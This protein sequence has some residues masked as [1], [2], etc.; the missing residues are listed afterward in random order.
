MKMRP[1]K[2]LLSRHAA[3]EIIRSNIKPLDKVEKVSLEEAAGRVLA[4][5]AVARFNVPPF[6]R[7]SMDGYA[8][9]A[10]DTYGAS[11]FSPNKLIVLGEQHAGEKFQAQVGQ[12]ECVQVATGSPIPQGSDAVVMVEHTKLDDTH[13]EIHQPAYPGANISPE[14]EDIRKGD[15][16]VKTGE[17]LTSSKVGALAAL[18][19]ESVKVYA[20]PK[21]AVISTG[22]EVIPL[23]VKL[24]AG[25][26]YDVNSFTLS[27][28]IS[29]N[30]CTPLRLGIV[31]DDRRSLED[32]LFEAVNHD[33]VVFSGG[34]SVG[35]RDLLYDVVEEKGEVLFH[36]LQVKPGKPTLFGLVEGTP[37][38][39]MPG[40]PTSCL[41]N[42]QLFLAPALRIA[43]RLP[44]HVPRQ[45]KARM[46]VRVVSSSGR[47]QFLTV[48][49][50]GDQAYPVFKKSGAIT[51]MT[52]ADGY[53]V[54]PINADVIEEG[55]EIT[56]TLFG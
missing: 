51:S 36:G 6:N 56:V 22:S 11:I 29:E 25:Q 13:V 47:E 40:Y 15:V 20:K 34:S 7:A 1:F 26:I 4:K 38:F 41:S 55:E 21:V 32:V 17:L 14:G 18:G 43:A 27:A 5:D 19:M 54:I 33:V 3:M 49:L 37:V 28:V 39:G 45:V 53:I 10:E 30:G 35:T 9:R 46:A 24:E 2:R 16:V 23:S 31:P 52:N 42:A 12:N 8:V 50:E 48:R 44:Q